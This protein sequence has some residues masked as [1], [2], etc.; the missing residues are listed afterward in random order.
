[1]LMMFEEVTWKIIYNMHMYAHIHRVISH[2]QSYRLTKNHGKSLKLFNRRFRDTPKTIYYIHGYLLEIDGKTMLLK[3]LC[4]LDTRHGEPNR[5]WPESL[6][7]SVAKS[8][9]QAAKVEKQWIALFSCKK[10][11]ELEQW[12]S[13][14]DKP[15]GAT[16]VFLTWG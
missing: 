9:I 12:L 16:M 7:L 11:H 3:T 6:S 13:Q 14:Q 8:C 10:I 15:N 5:N 2:T 4:T 1:M